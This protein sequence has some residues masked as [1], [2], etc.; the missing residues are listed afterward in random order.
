MHTGWFQDILP[1]ALRTLLRWTVII[2]VL[3]LLALAPLQPAV[4]QSPTPTPA[5]QATLAHTPTATLPPEANTNRD[6]TTGV[7]V[8]AIFL[9]VII[10]AG[11]LLTERSM[12]ER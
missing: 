10:V 5:P 9:I 6:Q 2:A 3:A 8:G 1:I 7:I 11:T 12:R 4:G